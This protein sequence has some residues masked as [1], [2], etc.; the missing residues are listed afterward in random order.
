MYIQYR[1]STPQRLYVR[2]VQRLYVRTVQYSTYGSRTSRRDNG[3][4]FT[5]KSALCHTTTYISKSKSMCH[6]SHRIREVRG[7]ADIDNFE[8]YTRTQTRSCTRTR[9]CRAE[10]RL[11]ATR[12]PATRHWLCP[13]YTCTCI[14]GSC[15]RV[16]RVMRDEHKNHNGSDRNTR[17]YRASAR[18]S[19]VHNP[20]VADATE[21]SIAIAWVLAIG[22]AKQTVGRTDGRTGWVALIPL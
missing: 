3:I 9:I 12:L 20:F 10:E 17:L 19:T 16:Q 22:E 21:L 8:S 4:P 15:G 13:L 14:G 1:T 18:S 7:W 11:P 2:T 6:S 5:V